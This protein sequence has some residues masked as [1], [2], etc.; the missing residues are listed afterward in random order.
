MKKT[1]AALV[2]AL[3]ISIGGCNIQPAKY[4]KP[5]QRQRPVPTQ[6]YVGDYE[7]NN[8]SLQEGKLES[9]EQSVEML[10]V[11][12]TYCPVGENG[13]CD[14]TKKSENVKWYGSG[15][16]VHQDNDYMYIL[17]AGHVAIPEPQIE[18]FF[19]D[20]YKLV[21]EPTITIASKKVAL[22]FM[23][24]VNNDNMDY[25]YLRTP[26]NSKLKV[27]DANIGDSSKISVGDMVYVLGYPLTTGRSLSEGIV[28]CIVQQNP[29]YTGG[30]V[31][32]EQFMFTSPISGGNSGGPIFTIKDGQLYLIGITVATW[33]NGQN[34]NIGVKISDILRY[35]NANIKY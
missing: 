16:V 34:L 23:A 33:T 8:H 26:K 5:E 30:K 25:A 14:T 13:Q 3:S 11:E 22:E 24:G 31:T 28:S 10:T 29:T 15:T 19:G 32:P 17:T 35:T 20:K 6:T 9:L 21:G 12:S 7:N 27:M 4:N 1:L 18:T 2:T